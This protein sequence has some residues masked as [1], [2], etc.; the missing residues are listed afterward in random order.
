MT[1]PAPAAE[2]W[3]L[4]AER[5]V[6]LDG[7][8]ALKHALRFGA[9][10]PLALAASRATALELAERLAPD[11]VDR[12]AGSLVEV[13]PQALRGLV[14]RPHPTGV[15]ALAVPAP[16]RP[17][18]LPPAAERPAPL[19]VLDE[20]RQLG[21]VG[22][23]VR[24]AAGVGAAGVLTTGTVDPWHPAV[25]RASAG[26]H[27]ALPVGRVTVP[28]LPAGPLFA[29]DPAGDDLRGLS[30]P[31]GSLLAFGSERAGLTD[32]LRA[33][34]DA[35]VALP[36]RPAVSSYNLA[37]SVAMALYHWL[38]AQPPGAAPE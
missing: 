16:A 18:G 27:Y 20:P 25:L 37:T 15:A 28:E 5:H 7:F 3:R 13:T 22:A 29:L 14:G 32:A 4:L 31:P 12:L 1:E 9:E 24:L 17:A 19:V 26:L 36:M 35:L 33:Q 23:V 11:L 8:H 38:A 30:L 2:R 10:V 21:N 6:L 34:A